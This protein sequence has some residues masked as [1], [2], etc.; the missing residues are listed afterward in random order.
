[1]AIAEAYPDLKT[2]KSFQDFQAQIEGT[3][4]R[5]N[6]ARRDYN[7]TVEGYNLQVRRFP[8]NIFAGWFHF[9]EKTYYQADAGTQNAPNIQFNIK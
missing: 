3:E 4:N 1:M 9:G 5:I 7:G 8:N 6:I 2:T